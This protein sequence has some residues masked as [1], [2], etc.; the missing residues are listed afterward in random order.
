MLT[1]LVL[2]TCQE[3]NTIAPLLAA[4]EREL[5]RACVLVVDDSSPDGTGEAVRADERYGF[6]VFLLERDLR[7]GVGA[8]YRECFAWALDHG[9]EAV[10]QMD[11][12]LS[13]PPELLGTLLEGLEEA[14]V[15]IGSRYVRG[16]HVADWSL[17]RRGHVV[18]RQ[19]LRPPNAALVYA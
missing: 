19:R 10:V 7:E 18:G 16:G 1:L 13:H 5:P 8:A 11:P 17:P 4:V 3:R 2:P 12:D 14:D 6:A 15:V 9:N